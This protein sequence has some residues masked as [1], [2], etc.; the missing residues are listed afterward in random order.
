M[1]GI[2]PIVPEEVAVQLHAFPGAALGTDDATVPVMVE[3]RPPEGKDGVG[4]MP[5]DICCVVDVSGSMGEEAVVK[6][7]AVETSGLQ[8]SVLDVVKHALKTIMHNLTGEDRMAVVAYS[9]EASKIFE[10]TVMSDN[11]RREAEAKLETLQPSGMTNLWDGLKT[12]MDLLKA[13][14]EKGRLQH[15]MLFTDGLPNINPPRGIL[16]MLKRLKDKDGG[17]LPCTVNT[18]GF[19]YELDSELLSQLAIAGAGSY[20]HIPDAGFVGTVFV[21]AL[22]NLLVTMAKDT[23]LT[24]EPANGASFATADPAL[25]GYSV[26][27]KAEGSVSLGLGMLQVGQSK[28]VVVNLKVPR[29]A[30]S[31]GYLRAKVEHTTRDLEARSV[32]DVFKDN[33]T[34]EMAAEVERHALRLKSVDML[35]EVMK[36]ANIKTDKGGFSAAAATFKEG[37]LAKMQAMVQDMITVIQGSP[38]SSKD[39]VKALLEDLTGQVSEATSREEWYSRWGIHFLPS[40][41]FAHLNQMCNNFKDAGVQ[42]YGS[43]VFMD[44]RDAADDVFI[45]LPAPTPSRRP[46]TSAAAPAAASAAAAP[47]VRVAPVTMAAFYNPSSGCF[48]GACRVLL[49]DGSLRRADEVR[50]GDL[51]AAAPGAPEASP[52]E[53]LCSVRTVVPGKRLALVE[54]EGGL[55]ITA[56][57]PVFAGGAWQFPADLAEAEER[58]CEAVFTFFLKEGGS[59]AVVEGVPCVSLGH[60][61]EEGAAAHPFLGSWRA[62]RDDLRRLPGYEAGSVDLAGMQRDPE[63]GLVCGLVG[64]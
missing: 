46:A 49:A 32:E 55:R 12:G 30:A 3:V 11:S 51:L 29:D 19:G 7:E 18:F 34:D 20:S 27:K 26:V 5:C 50:K 64:A 59:S 21:N 48:D 14:T 4:R 13:G 8:F 56:H 25:G 9:N 31:G 57:H 45:K 52:S 6:A 37:S 40:L 2:R 16:P 41:M 62:V 63:T 15:I 43:E 1:S 22:A 17:K 60:G 47:A 28:N 36:E 42:F 61:L 44:V 39:E 24:L 58:P 38:V 33:F 54:L 10:L 35:R 53:V 23:V